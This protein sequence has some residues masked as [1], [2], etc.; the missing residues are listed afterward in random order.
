MAIAIV[1]GTSTGIGVATAATQVR[2]GHTVTQPCAN[3]EPGS[4]LA[5][6]DGRARTSAD[7]HCR[8]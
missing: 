5:A 1:T 7:S 2:A 8:S 6:C 4:G 3:P